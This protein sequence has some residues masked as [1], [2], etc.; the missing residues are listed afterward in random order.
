MKIV[1]LADLH[2]KTDNPIC[3]LDQYFDTVMAK[4]KWIKETVGPDAK[5]LIAG[6]IFDTGKPQSF[7]KM[8]YV[9]A[10]LFSGNVVTIPGNHDLSYKS[11][12]YMNETA[13]GALS[14]I[15]GMHIEEPTILNDE[16]EIHPF[17]FGEEMEHR[18]PVFGRKMIA[19]THQ[20]VY[21][22]KLPFDLGVHALDLLHKFPE[23]A[24]ILSGDNHQ[25]F[26]F[27]DAGRFLVNPGSLMRMDA[28]QIDYKP[29]A[30]I[31]ED[32]KFSLLDIPIENNV[33][34]R[35]HIEVRS[36][37]LLARENIM[38]YLELAKTADSETYD[39]LA[40][41]LE[42]TQGLEDEIV[43]QILMDIYTELKDGE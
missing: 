2:I 17:G 22:K 28:D 39:F 31:L 34:S 16:Y 14:K 19:M 43:K 13:Y 24:I 21:D 35:K 23:Y 42:S 3:R 40:S 15:T 6:D 9:M 7:L 30:V 18:T 27:E 29:R 33:V 36:A 10:P 41:L 37:S 5:I 20:F 1:M 4:F 26:I 11:M 25:H 32:G 8:Y 38:A 12:G